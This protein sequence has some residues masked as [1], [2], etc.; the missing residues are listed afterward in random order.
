MLK[1]RSR[2][3]HSGRR[4]A[5][6]DDQP[7]KENHDIEYSLVGAGHNVREQASH[8]GYEATE[9]ERAEYRAAYEQFVVRSL[10]Q[11]LSGY[12]NETFE[13]LGAKAAPGGDLL[14]ASRILRPTGAPILLDWRLRPSPNGLHVLD[15]MV[16]GLSLIV[17]QRDEFA[18]VIR[19]TGGLRGL[20]AALKERTATL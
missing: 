2:L 7:G 17:T 3:Y 12:T 4:Q 1:S 18:A 10:A 13:V 15:L 5:G 9:P 6:C 16:E 19:S 11:R 8:H 20:V 14:V